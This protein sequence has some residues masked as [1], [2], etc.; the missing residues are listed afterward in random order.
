MQQCTTVTK[1]S[2]VSSQ[3]ASFALSTDIDFVV[4]VVPCPPACRQ[5]FL[6][7]IQEWAVVEA[8]IIP[9]NCKYWRAIYHQ[10]SVML[11]VE[12]PVVGVQE[13]QQVLGVVWPSDGNICTRNIFRNCST[14]HDTLAMLAW[15]I[16]FGLLAYDVSAVFP[17]FCQIETS[18]I[19]KYKMVKDFISF[20]VHYSPQ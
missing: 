2:G 15:Y 16:H 17:A 10:L 4:L 18:L 6:S 1:S 5:E 14:Q 3:A 9:D 11:R 12:I 8:D 20:Q 7:S 13:N 19:N